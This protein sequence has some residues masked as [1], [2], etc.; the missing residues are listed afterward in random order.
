MTNQVPKHTSSEAND[1]PAPIVGQD[2]EAEIGGALQLI[3]HR[4]LQ[5]G[6]AEERAE[7]AFDQQ[8]EAE[9]QQQAIQVIELVQVA[10]QQALDDHAEGA[11]QQRRQ[12]QHHPV[13]QP[14][15][16][17]PQ[18]GEHR[19]HHVQRAM[20]E[21]DD[22]EQAED[23]RQPEREDRVEAA[24]DQP[25][26]QLPQEGLQRN[27]EDLRHRPLIRCALLSGSHGRTL[28]KAAC[29]TLVA[30]ANSTITPTS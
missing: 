4:V 18:V 5:P 23:H 29:A 10:Q 3:G 8:R 28:S 17:Q 13:V 14:E 7:E 15:V 21:V 11:D 27:T 2:H 22:V 16:G 24:V 6:H 19:A 30:Q 1:H 26:Q 9:G 25:E 20:G 12:H